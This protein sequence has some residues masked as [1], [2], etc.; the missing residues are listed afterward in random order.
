[1]TGRDVLNSKVIEKSKKLII[2][3]PYLEGYYYYLITDKSVRTADV[4]IHTICNFVENANK[5][6]SQLTFNDFSIFLNKSRT[7]KNGEP[8]TNSY[9]ISVYHALKTYCTYLY[10]TKEISEN[11]ML[12]IPRPKANESQQTISKREKGYLTKEEIAIYLNGVKNGVGTDHAKVIQAKWRTRD[13]AVMLVFLTTGIRVSALAGLDVNDFDMANATLKVTDKGDKVKTYSLN[14]STVYALKDWLIDRASIKV[15]NESSLFLN[16]YGVR[17]S[18]D[19]YHE[20]VKKYAVTIN[21]KNITP[22]KLRATYGT[23]L[24]EAT[25]D[26]YFVQKA[27]GHSSPTTTERYIRG[28]DKVTAQASDIMGNLI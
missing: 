26:I 27:M 12:I 1:M 5:D 20:L 18:P 2:K 11:F 7:K 8:N 21:G 22:H 13:Y 16:Q 19:G 14:A 6:V 3:Y 25:K 24:Y 4:Y 28:Q 23:Q 10:N 9:I 15:A 17:M